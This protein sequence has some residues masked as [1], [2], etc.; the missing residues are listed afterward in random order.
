M[1]SL[2]SFE[3]NFKAYTCRSLNIGHISLHN[4]IFVITINIL[5]LYL[6][7]ERC[8]SQRITVRTA[9]KFNGFLNLF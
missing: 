5:S 3:Y 1:V 4:Y 7:M 9:E 6:R 8:A 2:L